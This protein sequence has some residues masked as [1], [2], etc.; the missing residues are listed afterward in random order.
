MTIVT[1]GAQEP[2][3][4]ARSDAGAARTVISA[5]PGLYSVFSTWASPGLS[6]FYGVGFTYDAANKLIGGVVTTWEAFLDDGSP[7]GRYFL[8]EGLSFPGARL[9]S[10][11]AFGD[12]E[13]PIS[14]PYEVTSGD[15]SITGGQHDDQLWGGPGDDTILGGGGDDDING[16]YSDLPNDDGSNYLRGGDG[17]DYVHGG[18][19]FDDINGNVGDDE[20]YG[21]PGDD[22]VLGGQGDDKLWGDS[23]TWSHQIDAIIDVGEGAD[24]LHGNLGDDTIDA[25]PGADTVLGGQG[26]DRL[27][28][29]AGNDWLSGDRGSDTISGGGGADTFHASNTSGVDRVLDFN[30][31]EG[32]RIQLDPGTSYSVSEAGAGVVI[33]FSGGAQ[34]VL[35][36]MSL[37]SLTE[38]WITT[39]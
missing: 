24:F 39:A 21:G 33:E 25:G 22:W 5:T 16:A 19:E 35:A 23:K 14:F 27:I 36:G 13:P 4:M 9:A 2:V 7:A 1:A 26:E 20:A 12:D 31:A 8:L 37:A 15:D 10:W 11:L 32:D 18:A 6:N 38:G 28:G 29:G 3:N 34:V 17:N 30:R